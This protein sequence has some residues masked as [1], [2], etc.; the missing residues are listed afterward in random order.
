MNI[1]ARN[2][3]SYKSKAGYDIY[4]IEGANVR[5][6]TIPGDVRYLTV[7]FTIGIDS[8]DHGAKNPGGVSFHYLAGQ[9]KDTG[10]KPIICKYASERDE[11]T[12][13][14]GFG[15]VGAECKY[16]HDPDLFG[17]GMK[18]ESVRSFNERSI[19]YEI[20]AHPD[21][22]MPSDWLLDAVAAH[23]AEILDY[24]ALLGKPLV[25]VP[26]WLVD[27]AK[28]DPQLNWDSFA[29]TVYHKRK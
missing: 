7:H 12:Y 25:L 26:H 18:L 6:R 24:W 22:R 3:L 13:H 10:D 23:L 27:S 5:K 1:E 15:L 20:E 17:S 29:R 4:K 11:V 19:G 8:R 28:S 9:Y 16:T 2:S 21:L 14:A